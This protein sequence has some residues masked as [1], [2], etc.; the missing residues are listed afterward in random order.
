MRPGKLWEHP[1]FT[2][3]SSWRPPLAV[4]WELDPPEQPSSRISRQEEGPHPG[5]S[6]FQFSLSQGQGEGDPP[7]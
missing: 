7:E 3:L 5:T 6:E 1:A 4:Q 2:H